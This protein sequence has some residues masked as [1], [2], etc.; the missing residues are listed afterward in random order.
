MENVPIMQHKKRPPL[1]KPENF[2]DEFLPNAKTLPDFDASLSPS[3]EEEIQE[4]KVFY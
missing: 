3:S 1:A 2:E 4:E